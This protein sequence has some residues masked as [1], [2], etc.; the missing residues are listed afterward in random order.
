[1]RY[2]DL[3]LSPTIPPRLTKTGEEG[4]GGQTETMLNPLWSGFELV[5]TDTSAELEIHMQ[6][7]YLS[8]KEKYGALICARNK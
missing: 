1:S 8:K 7:L 2:P 5:M 3:S 4:P 6:Q